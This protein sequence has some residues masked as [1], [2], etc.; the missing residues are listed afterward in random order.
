MRLAF[1]C[2]TGRDEGLG[3]GMGNLPV[4]QIFTGS[5]TVLR[6]LLPKSAST[7]LY[8]YEWKDWVTWGSLQNS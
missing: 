8:T 5:P 2:F 6:G 7:G 1:R 3:G 4:V